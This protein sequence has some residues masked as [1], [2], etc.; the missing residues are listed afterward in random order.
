MRA[1]RIVCLVC[2]L[3]VIAAGGV[4]S[5]EPPPT[6]HDHLRAIVHRSPA[7]EYR[8]A[9]SAGMA[10]V[11]A[12]E[13]DVLQDAGY[14]VTRLDFGLRR[15]AIDYRDG[16]SPMLERED[17]VRF[18]TESA[19]NLGATT[20]TDGRSL[21]CRVAAVDDVRPGDCGFIPF[22][23]ASPEWKNSPF[24]EVSADVQRIVTAGGAG[25]IVQG[26]VQRDLVFAQSVRS[27][28]PAV[29]AVADQRELIGRRV[30]LRAE[31]RFE[32]AGGLNV[33]GVRR[34]AGGT[35]AYVMLLAHADGWFQ[36]AADNGS[37]TAAVLRA[38]GL[39]AA[40][41]PSVGILVA[42]VDGEEI[43]LLGSKVLA[44]ALAG[45]G[46]D[47]GDG[48][49]PITTADIKAVVNLD[50][51]T[52]R[53]SEVQNA[54][55]GVARTDAP[56]FS[57][58]AMVASEEPVLAAAFAAVFAAHGILGAPMTAQVWQPFATGSFG[59]GYRSDVQHFARL[60]I[61]FAW[62]VAG[63]PEY[64]TDGDAL[65]AVDPQDLEAVAAAAADL[66]ERIGDLPIGRV[67]IGRARGPAPVLPAA[68]RAPQAHAG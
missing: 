10:A 43:G 3:Q 31:G 51:S 23:A 38:A 63:Y 55:R 41:P 12:Y 44:D 4:A 37:G 56:V 46:L 6:A 13:Q 16:H 27:S 30:R 20:G 53:A 66:T 1:V 9:G 17:G 32:D 15:W 65:G 22:A 36:A 26:D 48:G 52:A 47:P 24:V 8:R 7:P 61:P 40:R 11:A 67:A 2:L 49:A 50:A 33:I 18:K 35:G 19:F 59:G 64:H 5:A 34:P 28:V 42:L 60:G 45:A 57:W 25:V 14:A 68:L 39:L 62:P 58:R 21:E 54:V 29:V